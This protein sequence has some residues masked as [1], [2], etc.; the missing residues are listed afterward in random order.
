MNTKEAVQSLPEYVNVPLGELVESPTN[1]RKTFDD[2]RLEE[3][4]ESI[5]SKGVLSPLLARKVNGHFEIVSGARRYRAAQRAGLQEVPVRIVAPNDEEALETQIIENIQRADVHPFE[6][7]QGFRALL[8]REEAGYTVEKIAARTGKAAAHI[9]KRLRLLDLIPPVADAFTAGRIGIEHALLIA[10]LGADVQEDALRHC[11]DGYYAANDAER[12]LVPVSRLQAWIE[13]NVYLSLKSVPFSKDDETLVPE[14]GSCASCPK[15]TGFNTLL[16][17]EVR[18][19]SCAD[20]ACFNRKLDAH[21]AQRITKMPNLVQISENVRTT[22]ETPIL[23]RRNYVEVVT[24]GSKKRGEP[25]PEEKLCAHVT[26]AIHADGIDKGRLVKV[27]ADLT[28]KV[29]F[30]ERQQEEKQRLQ[31]KA[32]KTA[33]N[34]KA[35]QTLAFRHRLLADV[36]KR[37]KPQFGTEELRMVAQFILRSLSPELACRLAKRHGFQNP[38]DAHDWQMAEKA[39]TLYKK[40]D[41]AALAVL[42]FEAMLLG[43]AGSGTAHKDD[44]PLADAVRL[45]KV[46]AK[47]L[48]TTIA[49]AETEKAQ[50]KAEVTRAK[51]RP[52]HKIEKARK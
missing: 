32:E 22:G 36:L 50:S 31:W 38:K 41:A 42:I 3:L 39:R 26:T 18:E 24:R 9:A 12:S 15:R 33:A 51:N 28:C 8:E 5:R 2:E 25:R 21:I 46:D 43:A 17:S 29:H 47:A 48:R 6:E 20:A 49:K 37:V 45:Y 44:D 19:D 23:G 14:A 40:A 1:P 11:Y 16:F 27:C 7:A 35:K 4:A 34:Q 10:K 30:G 13:R 52:A